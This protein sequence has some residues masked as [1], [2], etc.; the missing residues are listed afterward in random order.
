MNPATDLFPQEELGPSDVQ[1]AVAPDVASLRNMGSPVHHLLE[2]KMCCICVA[3]VHILGP[4]GHSPSVSSPKTKKRF[5][6][7][8]GLYAG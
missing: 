2:E 8:V 1:A 3:C 7:V 4:V 5:F 6:L